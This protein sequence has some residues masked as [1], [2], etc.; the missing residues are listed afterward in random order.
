MLCIWLLLAA[1]CSSQQAAPGDDLAPIAYAEPAWQSAPGSLDATGLSAPVSFTFEPGTRAFALRAQ[2][3]EA[4]RTLPCLTLEDVVVNGDQS[5][6]PR[7][8]VADYGDFCTQCAQRVS[9][10]AGYGLFLLPSAADDALLLTEV[11]ARV[12]LRDCSTLTPQPLAALGTAGALQL[13]VS[14]WQ[15]P[16]A[17]TQL[18]LPVAV[19]VATQYG[20]AADTSLL[21]DALA[22][23]QR[24]WTAARI[25]LQLEPT[26]Q[27]TAP[28]PV[29]EYTASDR[30]ALVALGQAA[31]A[32]LSERARDARWPVMILGPCLRRLDVI[33][34][35]QSEPWAYTP[36][37]PGGSGVGDAPDQIFVAAERCE[38]LS[39]LPGFSDPA[40]LGTVMAHELG[41]YLGLYHVLEADGREDALSDTDASA[42]NL[43][44]ATPSASANIISASQINIA[45]RHNAFAVSPHSQL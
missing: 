18:H 17:A 22:T 34:G 25:E 23:M 30:A 27:I 40:L 39:A 16:P 2:L 13:D 4:A 45:R 42:P 32:G 12:A 44:R 3:T 41:H 8:Q 37:L 24:I 6:V 5:W 26:T 10:G 31:R 7:A 38:G 14:S 35:G 21:P 36:H 29:T 9:V 28:A 33:G 1:A 15:P 11:S 43:M 19:V 20:F